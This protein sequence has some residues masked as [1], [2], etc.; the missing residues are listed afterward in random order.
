MDFGLI[1]TMTGRGIRP[2]GWYKVATIA[3]FGHANPKAPGQGLSAYQAKKDRLTQPV[4]S[5]RSNT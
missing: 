1:K 2:T 5:S 4:S 3:G